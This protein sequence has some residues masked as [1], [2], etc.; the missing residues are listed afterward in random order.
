[1]HYGNLE[2]KSVESNVE[3]AG[4]A[5]EVSEGSF[6]TLSG[7]FVIFSSDSVVLVSWG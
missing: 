5:C 7:P 4:L 1:M 2:D 6:K 3:D